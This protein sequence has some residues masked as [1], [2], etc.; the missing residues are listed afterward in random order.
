MTLIYR[1]LGVAGLEFTIEGFTLLVDPFFTRPGMV[2]VLTSRRVQPD[3]SLSAR[4]APH[5]HAVLVTHPHYDHLMDVP[6]IARRTGAPVYGSAFTCQLLGLHGIPASQTRRVVVGDHFDAGP[7]R[8]EVLPALHPPLPF[9]RLY[10]AT[11]PDYPPAAVRQL[12][13][14]DYWMDV[15][16]SFRI[17]TGRLT[18]LVGNHPSPADLL[19][20]APYYAPEQLA[21][22]LRAVHPR[23]VVP[24]H[25]DDFTRPLSLPLRPMLVTPAQGL[26]PIFPPLR[27][28]DLSAFARL[29]R[30]VLPR[31]EVET[32]EIFTQLFAQ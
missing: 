29:A 10:H 22:I 32:P 18:V 9:T 30:S 2:A 16:Y 23:R 17:Q 4:H 7:F 24:I 5:A 13:L 6:A 27:R 11:L 19:F 21:A 25:W 3:E 26:R 31:V 28:L 20:L 1:W 12:R 14:S 8:V 15:S